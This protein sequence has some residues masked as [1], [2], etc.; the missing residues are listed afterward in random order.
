[1]QE[2]AVARDVL[3]LLTMSTA[4]FSPRHS[5]WNAPYLAH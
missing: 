4:I 3:K 5:M 1:M 2:M